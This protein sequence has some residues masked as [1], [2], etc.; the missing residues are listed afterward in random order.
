MLVPLVAALAAVSWA[1]SW[2]MHPEVDLEPWRAGPPLRPWATW[3]RQE[4]LWHGEGLSRR[5]DHVYVPLEEI[6]LELQLA[7]LVNEDL[8]FFGHG[9]VDFGAVKEAVTEWWR[10]GPLRGASTISQQTAKNLFLSG[11]RSFRRKFHELRLAWWLERELGKRR[12]LELYLN[13]AGFGPGVMGA[14]AASRRYFDVGAG[15]LTAEQAAGLAAALPAPSL[16]NPR[17]ESARWVR[18]RD[19][20][21]QRMTRVDWLRQKLIVVNGPR[22]LPEPTVP[23]DGLLPLGGTA[24]AAK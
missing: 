12:V 7:V 4:R 3:L 8:D 18:R 16:D 9:P 15:A 6:S 14:E 1:L 13:V 24:E 5:V 21:V 10:G 22:P 2:W 11:E 20:I 17:T 23:A 19:V